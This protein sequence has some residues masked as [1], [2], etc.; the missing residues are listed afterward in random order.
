MTWKKMLD[1]GW[2]VRVVLV[3]WLVSAVFVVFLLGRLDWVVHHELY[4]FGLQFSLE[5][6]LGYWATVRMIYVFLATPI[7]LSATYFVLEVWRFVKEG[8]DRGMLAKAP[9]PA[10]PVKAQQKA[11][12]AEQ[13]HML[14]SCPKCKRVFS[15]PL[16]M[17]D[18]SGGKTKLVNVCPY[19]NNILGCAE[20]EDA[21]KKEEKNSFGFM[22]FEG[23]WSGNRLTTVARSP[24]ELHT[25]RLLGQLL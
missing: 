13:N 19:C 18:F 10:E 1:N 2:F 12:V 23:R 25:I 21:D 5:W 17:L 15:K 7:F 24:T 8:H 22:D 3:L 14:I 6:A 11:T 16:V 20:E 4:D 9:S